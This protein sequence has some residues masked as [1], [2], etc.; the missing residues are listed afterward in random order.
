[1]EKTTLLQRPFRPI[2]RARHTV[3]EEGVRVIH[4]ADS[5]QRFPSGKRNIVIRKAE[6]LNQPLRT[7]L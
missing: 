2:L 5:K 4:R 7:V 1:M 3:S 6:G